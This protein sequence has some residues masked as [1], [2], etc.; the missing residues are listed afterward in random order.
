MYCPCNDPIP[1]QHG[2]S[3][4]ISPNGVVLLQVR[5]G[6]LQQQVEGH[7]CVGAGEQIGN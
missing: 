2:V 6:A 3:T 4:V 5:H 1:P 7:G